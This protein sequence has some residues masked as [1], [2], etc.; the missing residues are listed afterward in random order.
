MHPSRVRMIFDGDL[1]PA[2]KFTQVKLRVPSSSGELV[3]RTIIKLT[4]R[5]KPMSLSIPDVSLLG[6]GG[7]MPLEPRPHFVARLGPIA[8]P[9]REMLDVGAGM[10][11]ETAHAAKLGYRVTAID[12][13]IDRLLI[14]ASGLQNTLDAEAIGR[15]QLIHGD[16]LDVLPKLTGPYDLVWAS[17]VLGFLPSDDARRTAVRDLR[18]LKKPTGG[19]LAQ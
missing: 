4:A 19:V 9:G 11:R 10:L 18:R 16:L 13:H 12:V 7:G 14:G 5:K 3:P 8:K 6:G 15:I 2:P 17:R 1:L